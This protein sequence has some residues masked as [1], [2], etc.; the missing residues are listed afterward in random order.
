MAA[1]HFVGLRRIV[2]CPPILTGL[3]APV[4]RRRNAG[5]R[6]RLPKMSFKVP[7]WPACEARL[8]RRGSL[9]LGIANGALEHWQSRGPGGQARYADAAIRRGL[10]LGTAFTLPLRQTEGLMAP[11]LPDHRGSWR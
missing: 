8:R 5:R 10:M 6:H 7:N 9:T 2:G 4:P 1:I 11:H 3:A